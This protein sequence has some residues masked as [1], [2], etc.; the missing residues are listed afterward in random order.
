[1]INFTKLSIPSRQQSGRQP[2]GGR[3]PYN[4]SCLLHNNPFIQHDIHQH[5][6]TFPF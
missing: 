2:K 5:A 6:V 3:L 4:V 1:M